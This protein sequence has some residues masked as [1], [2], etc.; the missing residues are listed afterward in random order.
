MMFL[1]RSAFWLTLA[2]LVIRPGVD[3]RDTAATLSSEAMARG[4]HFIA[5]QIESIECDSRR[6]SVR[7][8]CQDL[9][10]TGW[11]KHGAVQD[12]D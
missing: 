7:F 12:A 1:I 5:Q 10:L 11:A 4:S 6:L 3:V 9:D 2:F 8:H